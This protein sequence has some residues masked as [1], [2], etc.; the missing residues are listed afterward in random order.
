M[1]RHEDVNSLDRIEYSKVFASRQSSLILA[2]SAC[3]YIGKPIRGPFD[4]YGFCSALL[5]YGLG[6]FSAGRPPFRGA[7]CWCA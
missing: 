5:R 6:L 2:I 3:G 7:G 1:R 4:P